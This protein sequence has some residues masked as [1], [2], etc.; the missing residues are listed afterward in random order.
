MLGSQD[1]APQ[2]TALSQAIFVFSLF[3][4]GKKGVS[5]RLN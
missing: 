1:G 3:H 2:F 5:R 4:K